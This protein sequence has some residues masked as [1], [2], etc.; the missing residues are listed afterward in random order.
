MPAYATDIGKTC[1][2]CKEWKPL[3]DF[4]KDRSRRLGVMNT[5]RVCESARGR[6]YN[7][8]CRR[9]PK[10]CATCSRILLRPNWHQ[11][12]CVACDLFRQMQREGK[13]EAVRRR[14]LARKI[15]ANGYVLV[16][17]PGNRKWFREHRLVMEQELGRELDR[18]ET[19]H[20]INGDRTD[21][22]IGNLQLRR[23]KHGQGQ[24]HRCLDCGSQN[25]VA[26]AL[27][28]RTDQEA[29]PI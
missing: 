11:R 1:S 14:R 17:Q 24:A 13:R 3:K 20:H 22:R 19:V 6:E 27:A 23:G 29:L 15:D 7:A 16:R 26:V 8:R 18:N 21:N 4:H 10:K 9:V 25:V 2:R 12:R 5:C 28:T